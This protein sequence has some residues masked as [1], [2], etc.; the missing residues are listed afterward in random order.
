MPAATRRGL[1]CSAPHGGNLVPSIG[2]DILTYVEGFPGQHCLLGIC[3]EVRTQNGNRR[4]AP[5]WRG[6]QMSSLSEQVVTP[7]SPEPFRHRLGFVFLGIL[8]RWVDYNAL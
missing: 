3:M 6:P 4:E 2:V 7:P 1:R 5:E 8:G